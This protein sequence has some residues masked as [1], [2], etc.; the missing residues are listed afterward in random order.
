MRLGERGGLSRWN[1]A[2]R[3]PV[4]PPQP[5]PHGLHRVRRFGRVFLGT[6]GSGRA[7][8]RAQASLRYYTPYFPDLWRLRRMPEEIEWTPNCLVPRIQRKL[9]SSVLTA[10]LG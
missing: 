6:G 4:Q 9:P 2:L 3:A 1:C 10:A 8:D 7:G 5:S